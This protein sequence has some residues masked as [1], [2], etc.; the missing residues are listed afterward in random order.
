MSEIA[1]CTGAPFIGWFAAPSGASLWGA[2]GALMFVLLV[3]FCIQAAAATVVENRIEHLRK[4]HTEGWELLH[5]D[6]LDD[7]QNH[8]P[9]E[10]ARHAQQWDSDYAEFNTHF[11]R[12][13]RRCLNSHER[14]L[15]VNAEP[16]AN[17]DSFMGWYPQHFSAEQHGEL[18]LL[19]G[20]LIQLE[21]FISEKSS[22]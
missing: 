1:A 12:V 8:G 7:G 22:H 4:I 21:F 10:I 3:C 16:V 9:E 17:P 15:L 11:E 13:V 6:D 2:F 19:A 20:R 5:R 18:M 14:Q